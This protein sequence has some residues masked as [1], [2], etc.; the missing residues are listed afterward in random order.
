MKAI[1]AMAEMNL[2]KITTSPSY[3]G[4]FFMSNFIPDAIF[5]VC[6]ETTSIR[7]YEA[8]EFLQLDNEFDVFTRITID[9]I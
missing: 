1:A 8:K 7:R 4:L 3:D 5:Y 2:G 9:E 6:R